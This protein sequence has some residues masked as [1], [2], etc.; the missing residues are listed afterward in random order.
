MN[1]LKYIEHA[2]ENL[3]FWLWYRD[4]VTRFSNLPPTERCLAPEWTVEQ[5]EAENGANQNAPSAPKNLSREAA[6]VFAG[7]DFAP[8]K[9][10]RGNPFDTPPRTPADGSKRPSESIAGWSDTDSVMR[11]GDNQSVQLKAA[12]AFEKA[13][14]KWQPCKA[15]SATDSRGS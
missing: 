8:T 3:Q 5:A 15:A 6:A 9:F 14:L 12:G 13:D 11:G 1:Y 10:R 2:A 7:T 4:Y